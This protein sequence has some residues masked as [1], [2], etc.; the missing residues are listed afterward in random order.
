MANHVDNQTGAQVGTER[1]IGQLVADATHDVSTIVRSEIA[2]AKAEITADAKKAA[3]GAGMFA[4]AG[5][6]ALLGL[7]FFFH[8]VA[9]VISIWLPE[10]AGY[11][12]TTGLLFVVA[13][14]LALVGR[15]S[16]KGMRGKP[17]RTIKN[18]QE[19]LSTLKSG[20]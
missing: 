20:S 1:T 11:L 8:T 19:T 9:A 18:A 4:A 5:F 12:I 13:L 10:W 7:I 3:A 15:K 16:M 14:V 17:E 6:V 2:L